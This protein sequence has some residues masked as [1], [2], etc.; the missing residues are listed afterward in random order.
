MGPGGET[1]TRGVHILENC[2]CTAP[3]M[4][5]NEQTGHMDLQYNV[6]AT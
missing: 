3:S 2:Q 5:G 4:R 1:L 6:K